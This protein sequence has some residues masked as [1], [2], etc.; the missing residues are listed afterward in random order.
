MVMV[1]IAGGTGPLG[2]T[3]V[4]AV[5]ATKKHEGKV[6]SMKVRLIKCVE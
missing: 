4:E 3:I 1:A 6:L 5:L 2:R